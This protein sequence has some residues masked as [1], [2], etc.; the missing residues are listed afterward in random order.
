M[1]TWQVDVIGENRQPQRLR[2]SLFGGLLL[3]AE[4]LK[5]TNPAFTPTLTPFGDARREV[6]TLCDGT[7]TLEEIEWH[8]FHSHK[9]LFESPAQASAF[10]AKVLAKDA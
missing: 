5:R 6:L 9:S 8:V 10:V 7:H 3:S 4:T 1:I 2:Q